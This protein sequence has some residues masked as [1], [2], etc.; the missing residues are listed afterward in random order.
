MFLNDETSDKPK[1]D[2]VVKFKDEVV[3]ERGRS[4]SKKSQNTPSSGKAAGASILKDTSKTKTVVAQIEQKPNEPVKPS[5]TVK[6][7]NSKKGKAPLPPPPA[8]PLRGSCLNRTG[9]WLPRVYTLTCMKTVMK[10]A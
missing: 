5:P 3:P 1:E 7:V 6:P 10:T 4:R 8:L 9:L 2:R